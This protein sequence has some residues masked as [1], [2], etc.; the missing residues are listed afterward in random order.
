MTDYLETT[1]DKFN[2][3]VADDRFYTSEGVWAKEENG[4]IRLGLS[5]YV[6]QRSGDVAFADVRPVGKVLAAGDELAVI[7]TIKVNITYSSPING[8]I[9]EANP[10]VS[11]APEAINQDPYG[12]GW[13]AVMEAAD[14]EAQRARLL[15]PQAYFK[16]M[17][18]QA[19]EETK[20]L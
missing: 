10:A 5:D 14:W 1:V 7:E 12:T 11:D 9:V 17:K 16:V 20:K 19:E 15:D 4:R 6:Q 2:F 3:K 18:G 13:L 8:K